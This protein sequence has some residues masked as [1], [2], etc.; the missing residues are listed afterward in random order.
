[1]WQKGFFGMKTCRGSSSRSSK[2][3][4]GN[5]CTQKENDIGR[6]STA[7]LYIAN[8]SKR[9]AERAYTYLAVSAY[10]RLGI[11]EGVNWLVDAMERSEK[12]ETLR[13]GAGL[14]NSSS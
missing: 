3:A 2:Q 1:M 8:E 14:G 7:F 4:A 10:D 11:K 6:D 5:I 9:L 12:T 13:V